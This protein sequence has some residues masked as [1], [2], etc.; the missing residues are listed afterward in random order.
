MVTAELLNA[1]LRL[2][3]IR[4]PFKSLYNPKLEFIDIG[5][6]TFRLSMKIDTFDA[7]T[8]RRTF[9]L[10]ANGMSDAYMIER[11][12]RDLR[13]LGKYVFKCLSDYLNHELAESLLIDTDFVVEPKHWGPKE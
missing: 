8:G 4:D 7:R 1:Q 2:L 13:Y 5:N 9:E 6:E 11:F 12:T 3:T 10:E